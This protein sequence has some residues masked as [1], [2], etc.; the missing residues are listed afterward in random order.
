[1]RKILLLISAFMFVT[2]L[3]AQ[4]IKNKFDESKKYT[5]NIMQ[6]EP[7]NMENF[8]LF[9]DLFDIDVYSPNFNISFGTGANYKFNN[10]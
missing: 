6:N 5:Y 10:L 9:L 7:E 1:M 8:S 3:Y 2:C 4:R